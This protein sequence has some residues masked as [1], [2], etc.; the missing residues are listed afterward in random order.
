MFSPFTSFGR[1]L[2]VLNLQSYKQHVVRQ[3]VAT[4][5]FCIPCT[6]QPRGIVASLWETASSQWHRAL[7]LARSFAPTH[8]H[9]ARHFQLPPILRRPGGQSRGTSQD[10]PRSRGSDVPDL[11]RGRSHREGGSLS[12]SSLDVVVGRQN[13]RVPRVPAYPAEPGV[14]I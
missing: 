13:A 2:V 5:C 9:H 12:H 3:D 6:G 10:L 14:T 11:G 4:Q 8:C 7:S 1:I